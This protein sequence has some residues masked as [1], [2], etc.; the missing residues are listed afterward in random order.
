MRVSVA[1]VAGADK[2]ALTGNQ[3]TV[4]KSDPPA[5]AVDS[6]EF[7]QRDRA[8]DTSRMIVDRIDN[9]TLQD[10]RVHGRF[11]SRFVDAFTLTS[12]D[13]SPGGIAIRGGVAAKRAVAAC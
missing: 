2:E 6:P 7:G 1:C 12:E 3:V 8:F 5:A 13:M 9:R 11:E 10:P 4:W